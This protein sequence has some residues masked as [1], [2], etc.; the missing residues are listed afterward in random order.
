[1]NCVPGDQQ[2]APLVNSFGACDGAEAVDHRGEGSPGATNDACRRRWRTDRR[3]SG[4]GVG[5]GGEGPV[6]RWGAVPAG[7]SESKARAF[8]TSSAAAVREAPIRPRLARHHATANVERDV[9]AVLERLSEL[10]APALD[11]GLHA[12]DRDA[13]HLGC[14]LLRQAFELDQRERL[15]VRRREHR[16][17][18]GKVARQL[19]FD[20]AVVVVD[21]E[22]LFLASIGVD[23]SVLRGEALV[24][25]DGAPSNLVDPGPEAFLVAEPGEPALHAEEDVLHD[26]VDIDVRAHAARDER[27]QLRFEVPPCTTRR[28][29]D[30][31]EVSGAQQEGP[32]HDFAPTGFTASMVAEAT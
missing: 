20:G 30:H 2:S 14:L 21:I 27:P 12:R 19:L 31:A 8:D 22:R 32:Q 29:I 26:V 13:E 18:G 16:N 4:D 10:H 24:V 25:D 15:A 28:R 1:F 7:A 23:H 3:A 17:E 6:E 9:A 11:A 5:A